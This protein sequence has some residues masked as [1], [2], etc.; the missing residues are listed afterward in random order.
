M[1]K[2]IYAIK[3]T[4]CAA[5]LDILGGGRVNTLTCAYCHAMLDLNDHYKVLVKFNEIKRPD[6]PFEIGMQGTIQGLKWTI[7]GWISYKTIEFPSETWHEFFLYSPTHGY[8]WLINEKNQIS[9]SKRIRNFD[10]Y[11]WQTNYA[12]TIFYNKGHYIQKESKYDIYI[13]YV[14]G[15]LSWEAKFGDQIT[16]RDYHGVTKKII[17]IEQ[18]KKETE[19]YL[20]QGLNPITVYNA[21]NI[22]KEKR[23]IKRNIIERFESQQDSKKNTLEN[24]ET[25]DEE[26][27]TSIFRV[28]ITLFILLLVFAVS[29]KFYTKPIYETSFT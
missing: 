20:T 18:S 27:N 16:C 17:N 28:F 15:G 25:S 26:S 4:N 24:F 8:A 5:P 11:A 13:D 21:F 7:I 3:C 29:S 23:I 9:F 1:S 22:P 19:V 6:A 2:K 14:E 12:K 10:L